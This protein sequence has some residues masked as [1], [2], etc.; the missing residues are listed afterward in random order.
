MIVAD[1]PSQTQHTNC[2]F[3]QVPLKRANTRNVFQFAA[4]AEL[5]TNI[6]TGVV[7]VRQISDAQCHQQQSHYR[8]GVAQ[9]MPGI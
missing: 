6:D 4:D 3:R 1:V 8:P 2:Q 7:H 9:R 5:W